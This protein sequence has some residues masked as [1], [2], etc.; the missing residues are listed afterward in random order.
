MSSLQY[1]L[2]NKNYLPLAFFALLSILIMSPLFKPGYILMLDASGMS[3]GFGNHLFGQGIGERLPYHLIAGLADIVFP[4]WVVQKAVWFFAFLFAG[5]GAYKLC[6]AQSKVGKYFAG[7]IYMVNPFIYARFL[8]GQ[9]LL[10]LSYA[11]I[12]FAIYYFI[13]LLEKGD[14][15]SLVLTAILATIIGTL[16]LH[17]LALTLL[18]FLV[19]L[20]AKMIQ[21]RRDSHYLLAVTKRVGLLS[22]VFLLLNIY[23]L[24]PLLT[25]ESTPLGQL[26]T[27]DMLYFVPRDTTGLGVG[28]SILSLHG[29]WHGGYLYTKDI[30][31]GW[32]L[33]AAFILFLSIYGI[34]I[35]WRDEKHGI[36]VKGLTIIGVIAIIL[37][38]GVSSSVTKLLF[39]FLWDHLFFFPAFRD[40]QK[41]VALLVLAYS[42]L[43]G[44]GVA[45]FAEGLSKDRLAKIARV[46]LTAVIAIALIAPLLYC[47][48]IF[49][50][51]WN[52]IKPTDLPKDWY[53]VNEFLNEDSDD[54]NVIFL[55]WHGYIDYD[56]LPQTSKRTR[57]FADWFF[58]KPVIGGDNIEI[59]SI[60]TQSPNPISRYIEFLFGLPDQRDRDMTN[61]GELASL[62]DAKYLLLTKEA[63]WEWYYEFLSRQ[64]DLTLVK[65][66]THLLVF[67]NEHSTARIYQVSNV[68]YIKDW[69]ELLVRSKSEDVMDYLYMIGDGEEISSG[70]N[71]QPATYQI[72]SPAKYV[73]EGSTKG[74]VIFVP[75]QD[76]NASHWEYDD[77]GSLKHLGFMP[78]F[79]TNKAAVELVYTRFYHVYLPSYI[80]SIVATA[81]V[82]W[83]YFRRGTRSGKEL[84]VTDL[85]SG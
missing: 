81:L 58:D 25:A 4:Y 43:G 62:V 46:S 67:K 23:W 71:V 30:L 66:T 61:L 76:M 12:P 55:P 19:V 51:F 36:Y 35:K 1:R 40:S 15:K 85:A 7:I 16:T 74:Y 52:Q 34:I 54:F 9:S 24:V 83:F 31:P 60:Y 28:L 41:F 10:V 11:L 8:A 64:E 80:T 70:G 59:G 69:D 50:G 79:E 53:E 20:I 47:F 2:L 42:F 27:G 56:W 33:V 38:L 5:L 63:D 44:L 49:N 6:P 29:F 82:V 72:K 14:K 32:W 77:K 22:A 13:A 65:E 45:G 75:T 57:N 84:T 3:L 18:A 37:A 21:K 78:A 48:T 73:I 17:M 26:G 39:T 68:A